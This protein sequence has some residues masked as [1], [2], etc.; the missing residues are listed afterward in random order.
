MSNCLL[1]NI[2]RKQFLLPPKQRQTYKNTLILKAGVPRF[3]FFVALSLSLSSFLFATL[4]RHQL[5]LAPTTVG[6]TSPE[7]RCGLLSAPQTPGRR[8]VIHPEMRLSY[9][10]VD[11]NRVPG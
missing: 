4:H 3:R 9:W 7:R 10:G 5:H 8:A 11:G 6:L 2:S 1:Y